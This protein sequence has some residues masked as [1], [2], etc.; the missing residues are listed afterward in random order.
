MRPGMTGSELTDD[1]RHNGAMDGG[2]SL[3]LALEVV[4]QIHGLVFVDENQNGQLDSEEVERKQTQITLESIATGQQY[5][6]QA[7]IESPGK[8]SFA[9]L[10]TGDYRLLVGAVPGFAAVAPR[11]VTISADVSGLSRQCWF[12]TRATG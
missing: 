9:G 4:S 6:V 1:I 10:P 11:D 12:D 7:G 8:F 5:H 2:G 3:Q